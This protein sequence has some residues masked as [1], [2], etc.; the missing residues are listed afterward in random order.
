MNGLYI[1]DI[2]MAY[3]IFII[4]KEIRTLFITKYNMRLITRIIP[5]GC[6]FVKYTVDYAEESYEI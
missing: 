5:N 3:R 2:I 1:G 6:E 4:G